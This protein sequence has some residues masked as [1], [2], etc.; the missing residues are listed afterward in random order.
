MFERVRSLWSQS[1]NGNGNGRG[2]RVSF[3]ELVRIHFRWAN[4]EELPDERTRAAERYRDA[5]TAFEEQHGQLVD[6]YWCRDEASAVALTSK[7]RPRRFGI[8]SRPPEYRLHRVTD[9]VTAGKGELADLL[10]ECD[11]LAL[12]AAESPLRIPKAVMLRWL[13]AVETHVLGFVE[14]HPAAPAEEVTRFVQAERQ[15]LRRVETYYRSSGERWGRWW[16]VVGMILGGGVLLGAAASLL[17]LALWYFGL[18]S[19]TDLQI[20]QLYAAIGAGGVG[21]FVSVL[22]RMSGRRGGFNIDHE[23]GRF[24]VG[25]LGAYRPLL[26]AISGVVLY[27]IVQTPLL[28]IESA[29][30]T[31]E[32]VVVVAFLAGFS[33]AWTKVVLGGAMRTIAPPADAPDGPRDDPPDADDEVDGTGV[34]AARG[35]GAP[36]RLRAGA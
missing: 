22:F 4:I 6:A 12:K 3:S 10:H 24:R 26:G 27:L 8:L 5:V 17:G 32:Y 36:S 21:A 18:Y 2:R 11:V 28:P 9:W 23:L 25:L 29:A 34:T 15:R 30:L 7:E 31:L 1:T 16:Y 35:G 14:R 33:E 20:R 19:R 13:L